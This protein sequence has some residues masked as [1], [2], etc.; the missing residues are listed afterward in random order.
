MPTTLRVVAT[1]K[2]KKK[3]Y[4]YNIHTYIIYIHIYIKYLYIYNIY[5]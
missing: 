4:I 2:K 5:I 3:T 1:S